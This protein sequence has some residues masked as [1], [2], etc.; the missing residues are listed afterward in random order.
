MQTLDASAETVRPRVLMIDPIA[1]AEM[2]ERV[3]T[4]TI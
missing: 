4:T 1:Y 2:T 3:F